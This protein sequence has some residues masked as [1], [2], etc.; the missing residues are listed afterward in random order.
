MTV[1]ENDVTK[2]LRRAAVR[3]TRAPSVHNTQPWRLT[4][5]ADSLELHADRRRQ[6]RVLDP[7]CRQLLISCG[8][9]LFNARSSLAHSGY[10][11]VVVRLPDPARPDL[12]ARIHAESPVHPVNAAVA[13]LDDAIDLRG[14]DR[15]EFAADVVSEESVAAI[16]SAAE[17]EGA[18]VMPIVRTDDRLT[19]DRLSRLAEQVEL[20]DPAYRAELRAW[21]AWM[22]SR[23][24]STLDEPLLLV[25]ARA[26]NPGAWLQTG[27]ALERM[28]LEASRRGYSATPLTQLIE[29]AR[30]NAELR[31]DLE[32]T[33]HPHVLLRI[34]SGSSAPETRRRRL[35]DVL[36]DVA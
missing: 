16:V 31:R 29:V 9:A 27:E 30:T 15:A 36:T 34:G 7:R 4:L 22:P 23:S 3:A 28:L 1:A 32:L 21:T 33:M 17:L 20:T 24:G 25:G 35:V 6:L 12:V 5:T 18:E 8:C 14:V 13:A 19:M 26:D 11:A 2:A 10:Q